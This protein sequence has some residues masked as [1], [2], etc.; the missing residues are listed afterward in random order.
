MVCIILGM[1]FCIVLTTKN[2]PATNAVVDFPGT[3]AQLVND[4]MGGSP[5]AWLKQA[6]LILVIFEAFPE[7]VM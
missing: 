1:F 5:A 4:T 7:W 2:P 3:A 6:P